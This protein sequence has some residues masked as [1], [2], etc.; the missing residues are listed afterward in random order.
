MDIGTG[1]A[2]CGPSIGLCGLLIVVVKTFWGSRKDGNGLCAKTCPEHLTMATELAA[3]KTSMEAIGTGV[4]ELKEG[5]KGMHSRL[6]EFIN[7][8]VKV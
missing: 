2:I 8:F 7:K 1:V 5:Q 4:E 3:V 6:D